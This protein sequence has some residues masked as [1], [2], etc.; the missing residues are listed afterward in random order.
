MGKNIREMLKELN[1]A[2][3]K[4]NRLT[5]TLL[6]AIDSGPGIMQSVIIDGKRRPMSNKDYEAFKA[7]VNQWNRVCDKL[8]SET[9]QLFHTSEE[10][11]DVE[12]G[13]PSED[14]RLI[15]ALRSYDQIEECLSGVHPHV[16]VIIP[17]N[18]K[19]N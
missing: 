2:Q 18:V 13:D 4:V 3:L 5:A 9:H 10:F 12:P 1:Q 19:D 15:K 7:I 11:F 8:T 14:D 16:T 17:R 6:I